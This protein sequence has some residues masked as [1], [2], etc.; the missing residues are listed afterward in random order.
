MSDRISQQ[1]EWPLLHAA[2]R[3]RE[4]ERETE[5]KTETD[6]EMEIGAER[7]DG[8]RRKREGGNIT[9]QMLYSL[10]YHCLSTVLLFCN[11]TLVLLCILILRGGEIKGVFY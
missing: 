10:Q 11:R 9:D 1:D 5:R 7:E 8:E 2:E 4:R 6:K 3:E